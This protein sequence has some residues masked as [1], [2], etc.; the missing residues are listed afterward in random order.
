MAS[1]QV[2]LSSLESDA[3]QFA[4]AKRTNAIAAA[5]NAFEARVAEVMKAHGDAIPA[6]ARVYFRTAE[7][8]GLVIE[9]ET[10]EAE[11]APAPAP[12]PA[13]VA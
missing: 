13:G 7:G 6:G 12:E 11:A 3:V 9:I 1:R 2:V 5:S 8:G 10:P 4:L